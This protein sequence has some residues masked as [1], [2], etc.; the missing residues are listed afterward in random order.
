MSFASL[1]AAALQYSPLS[2]YATLWDVDAASEGLGYALEDASPSRQVC[3]RQ[4]R[5][6]EKLYHLNSCGQG[7]N[8]CAS[9]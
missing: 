8:G 2:D 5:R 9:A 7:R 4:L 1:E 3:C 6:Q